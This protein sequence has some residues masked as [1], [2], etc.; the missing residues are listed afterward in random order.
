MMELPAPSLQIGFAMRLMSLKQKCLQLALKRAVSSVDIQDLD[1]EL[2]MYVGKEHLAKMAA[3]GLRGELLYAVPCIIMKS[4]ALLGYYRLLLGYSQKSFYNSSTGFSIFRKCEDDDV[5]TSNARSKLNEACLEL[6]NAGKILFDGIGAELISKN[7]LHELSLLTL[8]PQLRGAISNT[9]GQDG[10]KSV[11]QIILA[12]VKKSAIL[13]DETR[14]IIVV[15][16]AAKRRVTIEF[17]LDP[18]IVITEKVSEKTTKKIVAIEIKAGADIANIHNRLG[19]AEKSHQKAKL[20]G[21]A[22]CW[23]IFNVDLDYSV[24]RKETP[25][26]NRFYKLSC[27]LDPCSEEFDD[28]KDQVVYFTGIPNNNNII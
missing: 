22:E 13:H 7:L 14:G 2:V 23:T 16:N 15:E 12:I 6:C 4:P 8:G 5:L 20:D 10:I 17:S 11:F 19:E 9:I 21:F 3:K 26:T 27:L 18:D 25:S 24:A 28:F 1:K